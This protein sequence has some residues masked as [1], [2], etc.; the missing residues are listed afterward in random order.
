MGVVSPP[1]NV[2]VRLK[3][4]IAGEIK[5][6]EGGDVKMRLSDL[7]GNPVGCTEVSCGMKVS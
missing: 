2:S 6:G 3:N 1:G 7:R 4:K 5:G